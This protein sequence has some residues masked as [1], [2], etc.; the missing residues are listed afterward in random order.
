MIPSATSL[1]VSGAAAADAVQ[2]AARPT[3]LRAGCR[4]WWMTSHPSNLIPGKAARIVG[5]VAKLSFPHKG[6]CFHANEARSRA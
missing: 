4:C 5:V 2:R 1:M 6:S 3:D